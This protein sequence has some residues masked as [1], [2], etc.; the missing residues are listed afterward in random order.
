[1]GWMGCALLTK[2]NTLQHTATQCNFSQDT[3]TYCTTLQH[4]SKNKGGL[5]R[6]CIADKR[7]HAA[8][9]CNTLQHNAAHPQE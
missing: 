8:T 3:A 6:L 1:M 2:G 4:T 7:E 9:R 5:N